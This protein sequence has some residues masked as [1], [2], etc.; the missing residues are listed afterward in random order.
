M[1]VNNHRAIATGEEPLVEDQF[2]AD[3]DETFVC[4]LWLMMLQIIHVTHHWP[5]EYDGPCN[6]LSLLHKMAAKLHSAKVR[7]LMT[8]SRST[9]VVIGSKFYWVAWRS[10]E[11]N[12]TC[13]S[14][15]HHV[16]QRYMGSDRC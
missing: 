13:K 15:T 8:A 6:T 16:W 12:L 5:L 2:F 10:L 4:L 11:I 3:G 9:A 14:K 7:S 1:Y